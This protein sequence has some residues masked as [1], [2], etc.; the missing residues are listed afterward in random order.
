MTTLLVVDDDAMVR[1][2]IAM[3]LAVHPDLQIIGEAADGAEA[4]VMADEK[5]P[6]VVLMDINMPGL[7]GVSA[8][9]RLLGEG[10][11]GSRGGGRGKPP[12]RVLALTTFDDEG[13]VLRVIRAG[14][15]GFIVKDTAPALLAEAVRAVAAGNSWLD[16]SV[17]S[18]VL[19][20]LRREQPPERDRLTG[21]LATLTERELQVLRLMA[22]GLT[23]AEIGRRFV[24]SEATV[25][26]HVSRILMKTDCHDRTQA[27]VLAY[28]SGLVPVS[29]PPSPASGT[30]N[31]P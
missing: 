30:E 3:L 26:T 1:S 19:D 8:T 22:D 31:E 4:V 10:D 15:S 6:D 7:D 29:A 2:G 12:P 20:A 24:V 18:P 28:R 17:T 9:R 25:R 16:P 5:S 23:N 14:A 11:G 27:V 13:T 21:R